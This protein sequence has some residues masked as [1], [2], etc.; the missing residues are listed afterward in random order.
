M[1]WEEGDPQKAADLFAEGGSY[2]ATSFD[3]PMV[4][5][6]AIQGYWQ[7]GAGSS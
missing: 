2:Q 4:G 1:A 6:E 3:D 5:K 7:A